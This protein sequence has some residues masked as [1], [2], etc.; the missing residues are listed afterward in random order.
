MVYSQVTPM[1]LGAAGQVTLQP[2]YEAW[3][4]YRTARAVA[5]DAAAPADWSAEF[6][7]LVREA[8]WH[9]R[10]YVHEADRLKWPT[11]RPEQMLVRVKACSQGP[12]LEAAEKLARC[13]VRAD[14]ATIWNVVD[15]TEAAIGLEIMIARH[16]NQMRSLLEAQASPV[17]VGVGARASRISG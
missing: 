3:D 8:A 13:V 2:L 11:G 1:P 6:G 5:F 10:R 15:L 14:P 7:R 12:L 4:R 16:H 17:P 9:V